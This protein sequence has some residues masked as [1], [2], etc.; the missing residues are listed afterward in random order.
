MNYS[1]TK[2]EK[3]KRFSINAD[4]LSSLSVKESGSECFGIVRMR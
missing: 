1:L 4:Y 3:N 2:P